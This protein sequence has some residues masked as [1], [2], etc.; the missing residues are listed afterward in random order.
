[1]DNANSCC[2]IILPGSEPGQTSEA[3]ASNVFRHQ[4]TREASVPMPSQQAG[5]TS[6]NL[7]TASQPG[8]PPVASAG[9]GSMSLE[10]KPPEVR[11]TG[12]AERQK[13]GAEVN[14]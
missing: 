14:I 7:A 10:N 6:P 1:M 11:I 8:P 13:T 2:F 5:L 12:G 9:V 4:L 3:N